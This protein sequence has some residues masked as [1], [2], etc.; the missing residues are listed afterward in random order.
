MSDAKNQSA[1][2]KNDLVESYL[3]IRT[4]IGILAVLLPVALFASQFLEAVIFAPS[5]SE[6]YYTPMREVLVGTI[7]AIAVFLIS[8]KGY[9]INEARAKGAWTERFLSD[10]RV[11]Y[12]AA[13][14]ALG[15]AFFLTFTKIDIALSPDP[16]MW[17]I[18]S[19]N[20][21]GLLH[22]VSAIMF[23]GA[24]GIFCLSNFRRGEEK[25][26]DDKR[27]NTFYFKCGVVLMA[28]I[29]ALIVIGAIIKFEVWPDFEVFADHGH[30]IF[31]VET[32]GLITFAAAWLRKGQALT[33]VPAALRQL[34]GL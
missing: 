11:S 31:W 8:Y 26:L 23:F 15:V 14:G 13:F 25:T 18:M 30:L 7:G 24:L 22:Q 12:W 20:T 27:E 10:R 19:L 5:I 6:F 1:E 21:A 17:S 16:L 34:V 2:P 3:R 32:V 29:L 28:C 9:P 33:T 4:A